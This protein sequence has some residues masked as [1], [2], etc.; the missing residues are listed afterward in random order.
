MAEISQMR[1]LLD[2]DSA[3]PDDKVHL[4]FALGNAYEELGEFG[5]AFDH[6]ARANKLKN[7]QFN[8][9]SDSKRAE[10]R[11]LRDFFT[12]E[13]LADLKTSVASADDPIFIVGMAACWFDLA[14][15]N[16]GKSF[17]R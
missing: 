7:Q 11:E 12:A 8:Y 16:S 5:E 13:R 6:Y 10:I 1:E 17:R 14:G 3:S 4:G 9:Y 2:S 15:T